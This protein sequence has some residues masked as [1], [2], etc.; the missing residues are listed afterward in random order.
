RP[1]EKVSWNMAQEFEAVTG[2]RLPTEAEW[3]YA[4]RAGTATAFNNGSND[5]ATLGTIAWYGFFGGGGTSG[6][7]THPVGQK[8][9]NTLGFHDMH[10]NVL[11]WTGDWY[12]DTYYSTSPDMDPPGPN[13]GVVRVLRG[14]SW[15]EPSGICRVS[16][17]GPQ[18]PSDDRDD[19]GVRVART[20]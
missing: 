2:L 10:G 4:S 14:G 16:H 13:S 12:S 9:A 19:A 20:P 15:F 3:E 5:D 7:Q 18:G 6:G 1:V 17:R 8:L 11:E